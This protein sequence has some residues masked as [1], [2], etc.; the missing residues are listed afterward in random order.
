MPKISFHP[1]FTG[2]LAI[3]F[4]CNEINKEH[5]TA[6]LVKYKKGKQI[7]LVD[8]MSPDIKC[9]APDTILQGGTL[10]ANISLK[11]SVFKMVNVYT[12]ADETEP[13]VD[14]GTGELINGAAKLEIINE[15]AVYRITSYNSNADYSLPIFIL[16]RDENKVYH[17]KTWKLKFHVK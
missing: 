8:T 11:N 15:T 2:V 7:A 16:A 9:I 13:L 1:L 3:L 12:Y 14:T 4:S 5:T 17:L 6:L 10:A